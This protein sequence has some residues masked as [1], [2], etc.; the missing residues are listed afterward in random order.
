MAPL[1]ENVPTKALPA[2]FVILTPVKVP[3]LVLK[4]GKLVGV[5]EVLAA[6]PEVLNETGPTVWVAMT[7]WAGAAAATITMPPASRRD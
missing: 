1:P 3:K 6:V 4:P 5:V 7:A 2:A